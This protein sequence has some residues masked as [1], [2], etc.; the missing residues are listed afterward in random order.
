[1]ELFFNTGKPKFFVYRSEDHFAKQCSAVKEQTKKKNSQETQD[2]TEVVEG[3]EVIANSSSFSSEFLNPEKMSMSLTSTTTQVSL[4]LSSQT[5]ENDL[6]TCNGIE[7]TI[8]SL[9]PLKRP[10]SSNSSEVLSAVYEDGFTLVNNNKGRKID[11]CFIKPAAKK[12]NKNND[13]YPRSQI[14][15]NAG[16]PML[17]FKNVA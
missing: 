14:E 2:P 3:A 4:Y 17:S 9:F 15:V 6:P 13:A 8:P 12:H 11:G 7:T 16:L 5:K 10:I 1:M